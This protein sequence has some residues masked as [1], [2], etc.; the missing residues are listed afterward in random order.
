M[1]AC[2]CAYVRA[3]RGELVQNSVSSQMSLFTVNA[4]FPIVTHNQGSFRET[5]AV[6]YNLVLRSTGPSFYTIPANINTKTFYAKSIN[7]SQL[8]CIF[9]NIDI[10]TH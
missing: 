2:V 9:A 3:W 6:P 7:R 4:T 8:V 1:R 5:S 10:L